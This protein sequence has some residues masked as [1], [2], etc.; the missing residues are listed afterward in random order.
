VSKLRQSC[1]LAIC[2]SG[3]LAWAV[4]ARDIRVGVVTDGPAGRVIFSGAAIEREVLNVASPDTRISLPPDKRFAGDWSL[5]GAAAALDRALADPA[6]DVVITLGV[7]TSQQAAQRQKLSKP[8]IAPLVIDPVL[9]A[10]PL[11]EGRSGRHNFSY[12][13]DFQSV[14]NE[15]RAFHQIVGF[16]HMGVLID[17]SLL[18]A[19]PQLKAKADELAAALNV[20]IS[21][22]RAGDDVKAM[23]AAIPADVD[24]VYVTP[25]RYGEEDLRGLARELAARRLPSFSVVGRSEVEGGLLMSTGGAE[26]DVERLA[27]RVVLMIQRIADGEDPARFEVGFPTS[28]R[29]LINMNV[30]RDIGFSPRWQFLADA[31]QLFAEPAGAQPLTLLEA[32]RAALDANPA[33]AASRERLGSAQEDVRISRSDLLPQLGANAARTRIDEDRASPL[34]QAEDTTS[35]GAQFSQVIYS[36]RAW[37][38]YSI[39]K[40]LAEAQLQSQRTD[41]LDTLNDAAAAYLNLLRTKSV[42][43]VR[44][45]NVENTRRNLETSRVREEVGLGGRSDYLRWVAQLATDKQTLLAAESQRRQA[46]TEVMRILHRPASQPISTVE[47][48]LDDPLALISS[49]RTQA[50]L[51]TPARWA[52]FMEY[53]VHTALRNAPEIAQ[54]EAV[55]SARQRALDSA[56]RSF[57]LPELALVSNGSRYTDRSGAGSLSIPGAPDDEAWSV[58]LQAT[59]PL[60]TGG[61]RGAQRSQARHDLRAGEADRSSAIDGIEARTRVVLHRTASSWP[62][63]ELSREAAAASEENLGNV[64][65]AYA[66]GAVSVTDLI[67]A[68]EA[69]LAAGLSATDAKYG[70]L[71]DFVN[72]LRSMGEFEILLD[73]TTREAWYQRMETWL[74]DNPQPR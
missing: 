5:P 72:V 47:T 52:R 65:E 15:V 30:A 42:E 21:L 55:V 9:Q 45:H 22:V 31:E 43:E 25:L 51:D 61:L 56:T 33:L 57:Y 23:L 70:F 4:E 28:Q 60:V 73:P 62:A 58:T 38:G 48:G 40:S 36:E 71:I 74:R 27:R 2:L 16:R 6:V 37:A 11:V 39:S 64:T 35:V 19:L 17:D 32:M 26:R 59:L 7:L 66:R 68:Q 14:G 13:A 54:A 67:D 10:Y 8:V 46:E 63:I 12:V 24:A 3:L 53:A 34:I 44:R 69:A 49:P 20:R 50:F 29:L 18:A 1:V 41:M